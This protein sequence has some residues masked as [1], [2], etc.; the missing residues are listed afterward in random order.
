MGKVLLQVADAESG[1]QTLSPG[2]PDP[3]TA[4]VP[5]PALKLGAAETGPLQAKT[6]FTA[7][8]DASYLLVGGLGGLGLAFA[9][10]LAQNGAKH[11]ILSSKRWVSSF[12]H[13]TID[14]LQSVTRVPI[15]AG[16]GASY[17]SRP[18]DSA[19]TL[20]DLVFLSLQESRLCRE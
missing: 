4:V 1:C 15:R 14:P 13:T 6:V 2:L 3:G 5:V 16:C 11:L 20:H 19:P 12:S 18:R 7:R 10:W 8:P 17:K 9:A